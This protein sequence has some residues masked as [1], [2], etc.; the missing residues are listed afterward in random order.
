MKLKEMIKKIIYSY[1]SSSEKYIEHLKNIGI[2]LGENI[3]IFCPKDTHIDTNNPHLLKIGNNVKMTGPV[4]ILTHDYSTSVLNKIDKRIYGKSKCTSI[5]NN[6]FL[7]WGCTILAGTNINDNVIIGAGAVAS[8]NIERDSVYA[9]NPAKKI[10]S[11]EEYRKKIES[12]QKDEAFSI[13][14]N[15][16]DRFD[17]TPDINVFHEYFYLFENC[18]ESLTEQLKRKLSEEE[19][20]KEEFE[21]NNSEFKSF[22]DF[23][24]YCEER[25]E[26]E[27]KKC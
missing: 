8:G 4:T 25:Y 24:V 1:K 13:Y 2:D 27:K 16:I 11:I 22:N 5:G 26:D 14:K 12:K 15:Y 6:V 20:T 3:Y 9:G 19:I 21:K 18:Y 23:L 10:M 17:K 7:G